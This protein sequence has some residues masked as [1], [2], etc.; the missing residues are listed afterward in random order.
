LP[1]NRRTIPLFSFFLRYVMF[2]PRVESAAM[3]PPRD[4]VYISIF[5]DITVSEWEQYD[6]VICVRAI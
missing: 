5:I 2:K 3:P 4:Y 6:V 1:G